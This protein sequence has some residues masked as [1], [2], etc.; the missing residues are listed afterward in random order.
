MPLKASEVLS[1]LRLLNTAERNREMRMLK[2]LQRSY[3]ITRKSGSQSTER[4]F[5][6]HGWLRDEL[7]R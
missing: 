5:P 1:D 7:R 2:A 4:L 6:L 3:S